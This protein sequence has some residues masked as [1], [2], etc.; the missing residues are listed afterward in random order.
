MTEVEHLLSEAMPAVGAAIVAYGAAVLTRAEDA[1]VDLTAN[2]GRRVLLAVTRTG[3]RRAPVELAIADVAK[4]ADDPMAL[5]ALHHQLRCILAEQ[6][7]LAAELAGVL[8]VAPRVS[9]SGPR[10]VAIGGNNT[11]PLTTGDHSPIT[12]SR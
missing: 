6:P 12:W 9:A 2:F 3:T 10:S 4:A 5:A 8:S 1:A 11:A 7:A